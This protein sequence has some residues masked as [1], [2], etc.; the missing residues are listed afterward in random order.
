[1]NTFDNEQ[2]KLSENNEIINR[3]VAIGSARTNGVRF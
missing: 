3:L 1:M 2:I